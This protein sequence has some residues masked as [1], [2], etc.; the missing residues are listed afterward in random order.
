[1]TDAISRDAVIS[2]LKERQE[3]YAD[4]NDGRRMF[5]IANA[6]QDVLNLPS[7]ENP[8]KAGHPSENMWVIVRLENG[9]YNFDYWDGKRWK[10]HDPERFVT[11]RIV[12]WS[13]YVDPC[14]DAQ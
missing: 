6:I 10:N 12:A 14:K 4:K 5:A 11:P 13:D 8:W 9:D 7:I 1:M 3:Y 2:I